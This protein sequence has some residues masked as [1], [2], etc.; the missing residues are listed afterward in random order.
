MY[1]NCVIFQVSKPL[2]LAFYKLESKTF[3]GESSSC[4]KRE[5]L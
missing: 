2:V 1:A 4:R 3:A 5:A